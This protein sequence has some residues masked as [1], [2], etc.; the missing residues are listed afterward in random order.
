M[1]IIDSYKALWAK[2]SDKGEVFKWLPL[3]IHS[4][5][6][7]NIMG[8]LWEHWLC[9]GQQDY[10]TNSMGYN[11]IDKAKNVAMFLG[12]IHDI[13]KST[14]AFQTQ[15]RGNNYSDLDSILLEKLESVGFDNISKL[16]LA[17]P[18]LS[19]HTI[20][21]EYILSI[22]NIKNDIAS[23]VG[24][25]HGKS[26]KSFSDIKNQ[27]FYLSNYYQT[28]NSSDKVY[29]KWERMQRYFLEEAL[30]RCD[31]NTVDELPEIPKNTQILLLGLLIMADWISSNELY[32][33]LID[34]SES[35]VDNYENRLETG[36]IKWYK[37]NPWDSSISLNSFDFYEK[38][39][40]F[41]PRSFQENIYNEINNLNNPG[42]IIIEAPMGL[43]KTEAALA[44][45]EQLAKKSGRNGLLFGLPTQ[46]TSNGIFPRVNSW[47]Q[48][49]TEDINDK[50]SIRLQHGKSAFNEEYMNL[51]ISENINIDDNKGGVFTNQWFSGRKTAVL[52]DFVVATVD[53]I[54]MIALKQ[55][56]LALRHLGVSKKIVVIDEVHAYDTYMSQY[57]YKAIEYLGTYNIPV[58]LLSAT[59]PSK[60]RQKLVSYY[61]KGKGIKKIDIKED[62]EKLNIESY[63]LLTMTD[64]KEIIQFNNFDVEKGKSVLIKNLSDVSLY[65]VI[66]ELYENNGIIGIIVNTV[67]RAQEIAKECSNI[68]GDEAVYLLHSNFIDSQRAEKEKELMKLVSKEGNRPKR[69]I[70]IG[71][72]VLEQSLDIDFDVLITDLCPMDLLIQRLGRLQRHKLKLGERSGYFNKPTVYVLGLSDDFDF[73]KGSKSI[74]G[75]Y[76]LARTQYFLQKSINIPNDI[77]KLVQAVYN[78]EDI[79]LVGENKTIYE[80]AKNE[81]KS[82]LENKKNKARTFLLESPKLKVNATENN[83]IGWTNLSVND[84]EETA[85]AQVRDIDETL[86]VIALTEDDIT[87]KSSIDLAKQT[88]RLNRNMLG[89]CNFDKVINN[90]EIYTRKNL[91][92]WEDDIWLKGKLG[93]I[94][95][96][97]KTFK[98]DNLFLEYDQK[99][100]LIKHK[101]GDNEQF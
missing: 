86:E 92:Y 66:K 1:I 83:L 10:I 72:Q 99:Y 13:G 95:D 45:V 73:E 43:G 101:E 79:Q 84:S 71:T 17:S 58:V 21:G 82:M 27:K 50:L 37:S 48:N 63:P 25:H 61:L 53:Q 67:R 12:Y 74:Y 5:D 2:K 57:L 88:I 41:F 59:L 94:F 34:I 30:N 91:P 100:G 29:K 18:K 96:D 80:N 97:S 36:W 85:Y 93:I 24:A 4:L 89:Y 76:I 68:F 35:E 7:M 56:H 62:I 70:I 19:H 75:T 31:F 54:L 40:G 46:A 6:T 22:N 87:S 90:L 69:K 51:P 32:F 64:N 15:K 33:P 23:I 3:Y 52:D 44:T 77:S 42:L 81:Y 38:R 55:K 28:E 39:F 60:T 47:L 16:S 8:L 65:N 49:I 26:V 78:E 9:K 14:P 20:S 11:D 98:L